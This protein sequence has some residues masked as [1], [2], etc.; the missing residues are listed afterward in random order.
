MRRNVPDGL[1]LP[2]KP[3]PKHTKRGQ[4]AESKKLAILFL[5][6]DGER[7]V[8]EMRPVPSPSLLFNAVMQL[9]RMGKL[10]EAKELDR[11]RKSI[12]SQAVI[13]RK[14]VKR[15]IRRIYRHGSRVYIVASVRKLL[16]Q[17]KHHFILL[18]TTPTALIIQLADEE[19]VSTYGTKL[20]L[21]EL[22]ARRH[23]KPEEIIRIADD[24]PEDD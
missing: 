5:G 17:R 8:R 13:R 21:E 20:Q 1:M 4:L 9:K 16:N 6:K 22:R 19:M 24:E 15:K 10:D 23:G 12:T 3:R 7:H 14:M 11:F 18:T 2:P